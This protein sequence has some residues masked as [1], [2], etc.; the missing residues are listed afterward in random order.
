MPPRFLF[1]LTAWTVLL[2][3]VS[4][5]A[6]P[7]G[8]EIENT[9]VAVYAVGVD[10]GFV[11]VSNVVRTVTVGERTPSRTEFLRYGPGFASAEPVRV[12]TTEFSVSGQPAGPLQ[13]LPPPRDPAT[14][15][16]LDLSSPLPLVPTTVFRRGEPV[17]VR[18]TDPDQNLDS[19]VL[20]SV[21][22][23]L[24]ADAP[25]EQELLRLSETDIAS[26][27]FTG[28][29]PIDA[30]PTTRALFDGSLSV[31]VNT[32]LTAR[33]VDVEDDSDISS[34]EAWVDPAGI[35]FNSATGAPVDGARVTLIDIATGQPASVTGDDG[36][37]FPSTVTS[38]R[39][40]SDAGGTT[41]VVAAGG[42]QFPLVAPGTYRLEIETPSGYVAPSGAADEQ[43]Q[44]LPGAP[45][46][47]SVASRGEP[48]AVTGG[49]M[50]PLDLP[51]DPAAPALS[52][53][54]TARLTHAAPGDFV[55][56][57]LLV[58][59]RGSLS[60]AGIVITDWLPRGFRYE[61]GSAVLD[62]ATVNDPDIDPDG[63]TLHF[64][65][66]DVANGERRVLRYVAHVGA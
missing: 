23:T 10:S 34:H 39:A 15:S 43:L 60:G 19:Q 64:R 47:L 9:A 49:R 16:S 8:T 66:G 56:Y 25:D 20:E 52:L 24:V 21:F 41:Y 38:G 59:N 30:A 45:F 62:G 13:S 61:P 37:A 4:A 27:V 51:V 17:F 58:E 5:A 6:V 28:Y 36:S 11:S 44:L 48:F 40:E 63:R 18:L 65:I 31:V 50:D 7:P 53:T 26:G 33:Y 12:R 32:Q 46:R 3:T 42:W 35:V 2:A 57:E 14:G 55:P 29:V 54:K 1:I 22:V